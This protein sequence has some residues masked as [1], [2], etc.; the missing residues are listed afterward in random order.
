MV[1]CAR[2]SKKLVVGLL[3]DRS[4]SFGLLKHPKP[5][6][7]LYLY[8]RAACWYYD[9]SHPSVRSARPQRACRFGR[10][11]SSRST[12]PAA[13][14]GHAER[15][16]TTRP[17]RRRRRR[18]SR[19]ASP[20]AGSQH[21]TPHARS[22]W[23]GSTAFQSASLAAPTSNQP[24]IRCTSGSGSGGSCSVSVPFLSFLVRSCS[25]LT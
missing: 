4:E 13:A 20:L 10:Y 2:N 21:T 22:V 3:Y 16:G 5:S 17:V 15:T 14:A 1:V 8:R 11:V 24:D 7:R 23:S 19:A 25:G 18:R 9:T 12:T 6:S